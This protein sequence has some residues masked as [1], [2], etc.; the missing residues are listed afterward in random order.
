MSSTL[1]MKSFVQTS[2]YNIWFFGLPKPWLFYLSLFLSL[3]PVIFQVIILNSVYIKLLVFDSKYVQSL[4]YVSSLQFSGSYVFSLEWHV[5]FWLP[6]LL[7]ALEIISMSLLLISWCC[8]S[9]L[10]SSI[11]YVYFLINLCFTS[12]FKMEVDFTI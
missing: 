5:I 12:R 8:K 6:A 3:G 2:V 4:L 1:R 7:C 11:T 9:Y 10:L